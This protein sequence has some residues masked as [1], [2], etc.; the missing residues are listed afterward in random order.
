LAAQWLPVLVASGTDESATEDGLWTLCFYR[1]YQ[2]LRKV[3]ATPA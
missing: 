2:A 3:R 1:P